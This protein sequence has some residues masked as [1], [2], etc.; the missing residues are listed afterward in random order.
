VE[1]YKNNFVFSQDSWFKFS[2]GGMVE[3]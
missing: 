1:G 3:S 2:R